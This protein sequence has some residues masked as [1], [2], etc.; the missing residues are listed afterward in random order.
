MVAI[1]PERLARLAARNVDLAVA[2]APF[3]P[4]ELVE[5]AYWHPSRDQDPAVRWL[6]GMLAEAAGLLG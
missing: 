2:E 1:V 3:G 4:V 6:L 5:T